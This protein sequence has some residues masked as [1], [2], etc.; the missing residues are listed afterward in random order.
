MP[1]GQGV[2]LEMIDGSKGVTIKCRTSLMFSLL[3]PLYDQFRGLV[4]KFSSSTASLSLSIPTYISMISYI[5]ILHIYI[6]IELYTYTCGPA[7]AP[8][9]RCQEATG[10]TVLTRTLQLPGLAEAVLTIP[11]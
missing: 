8:G 2:N 6:T 4:S 5:Y 3:Y 9:S 10:R 11:G 1:C 7:R